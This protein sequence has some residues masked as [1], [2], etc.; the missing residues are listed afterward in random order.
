MSRI[1]ARLTRL[2]ARV[3]LPQQTK[4]RLVSPGEG[5]RQGRESQTENSLMN[6]RADLKVFGVGHIHQVESGAV[7]GNL[8]VVVETASCAATEAG[9]AA[10]VGIQ[11]SHRERVAGAGAVTTTGAMAGFGSVAR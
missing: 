7:G 3:G 6:C 11:G 5:E 4:S 2:F 1:V 9:R 10:A 8:N